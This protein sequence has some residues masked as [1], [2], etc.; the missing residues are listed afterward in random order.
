MG[1]AKVIAC[2]AALIF[3]QQNLARIYK[4]LSRGCHLYLVSRRPKTYVMPQSVRIRR[5]GVRG[6]LVVEGSSNR[7]TVLFGA[8]FSFTAVAEQLKWVGEVTRDYFQIVGK[9]SGYCYLHGDT[10]AF[11]LLASGWTQ[12]LAEQEVLYVGQAFG[13]EGERTALDRILSHKT[14]QRIYADH[15]STTF[16][17]F[18]TFL[19]ISEGASLIQ[20]GSLESF[21]SVEHVNVAPLVAS[22]LRPDVGRV[23]EQVALAE[24]ALISYFKPEYN[25]QHKKAFPGKGS[26]LALTLDKRGY[27][28]LAVSLSDGETG[29]RFWSAQRQSSRYH[30]FSKFLAIG[31]RCLGWIPRHRCGGG[32]TKPPAYRSENR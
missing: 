14:I 25:Q 30:R 4:D 22:S 7:T 12:E 18:I 8:P 11:A 10:W 21:A 23:R 2:E 5:G 24:A 9:R 1:V 28:N 16:D 6:K 26:P 29:V 19:Q 31:G 13:K 27:T 20:L 15:Q 17:I 32:R 3:R